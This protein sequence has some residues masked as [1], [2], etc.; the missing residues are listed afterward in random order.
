V[1]NVKAHYIK[2]NEQARVPSRFIILDC[3]AERKRDKQGEIQTWAL[4]VCTYLEWTKQ[5]KLI[6]VRSRYDSQTELWEDVSDFTR[7][8]KRTV[9]YAHNLN[10]D[11]RIS[12]A[13]S[14]LVLLGWTMRDMRLD[15]R[16]SWS[17]WNRNGTTLTLCDSTSIFPVTLDILG[18][19]LGIPKL[20]LP[21]STD[22][23]KLFK[24][25][26]RDVH[27]LT[28]AIIR[29]VTWMRTGQLGNWQ[30]TGA[31]QAWS[32]W[33]HNHYTHKIL[34][35]DNSDALA[36]ERAAMHAGRCEAWRWGKYDGDVWYEYDWSNSYP[37]I[38]RDSSLPV[39]LSG[40]LANL[41]PG[42]FETLAKRYAIL[43]EVEVDTSVACVPASHNGRVIWPTG[44][45][46]TTLWDPEIRLLREHGATI[47]VLRAWVYRREP[48][49]KEWAEWIIS[50]LHDPTSTL[51][52]WQKLILKHWSR[53]LIGRFGMRYR[54][55]E[56]FGTA[57][58]SRVS[59]SILYDT[60]SGQTSELIQIGSDLFT[61]GQLKEIDDGCP[62]I[63]S[64]IMSEARAKL[65]RVTQLIGESNVYYMDTDSLVVNSAGHKAIQEA[66]GTGIF[67]GL[68]SKGKFRQLQ[69]YGPRSI[70]CDKRPTVA[71]MPKSA[72]RDKTGEWVGE[73][74][75]GATESIRLGEI[76]SVRIKDSRFRLRYNS[77]RRFFDAN[78]TTRPYRLPEYL[79]DGGMPIQPTRREAAIANGYPS[80]LAHHTPTKLLP[81]LKRPPNSRNSRV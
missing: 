45:F 41:D 21:S 40:Q 80:M 25:C 74:W 26:E 50:S 60:D 65:W 30:M 12:G 24:R 33:R 29:H 18:K 54:S 72:V 19:T 79:P 73:V 42:K 71:G 5:G 68:R 52:A 66:N 2:A 61:S 43:A 38:A 44:Q 47:C 69:L 77:N 31:S 10:Y 39:R 1:R 63:T 57:P 32:H 51:D 76:D 48:A 13:L 11:L 14:Q 59:M 58:D 55:W 16:G 46:Q 9:L 64:Y 70:I 34:I 53:A 17:K 4:A 23:E 81:R 35:H 62:Q 27:I 22:R 37:R 15:G 36:A 3:E 75:R 67:E 6:Q 49:L 56:P 8:G 7:A 28:D 20:P 78:G